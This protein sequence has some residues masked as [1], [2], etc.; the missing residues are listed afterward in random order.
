VDRVAELYTRSW[1]LYSQGELAA[2]RQGFVEVAKSGLFQGAE[3]RRPEDYIA[4]IDR[5]LAAQAAQPAVAPAAQTPAPVPAAVTPVPVPVPV[6][7]SPAPTI[8]TPAPAP[9]PAPNAAAL[10]VAAPVPEQGGSIEA[11]NRKRGI[12][13][14]YTEAAVN[15]AVGQAQK[16]IAQGEFDTAAPAADAAEGMKRSSISERSSTGSI[17][18]A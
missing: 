3:G 10:A 16:L 6:T 4:T 8:V 18:N 5:L 17:P 2:A 14:S 11:I 12:I 9:A 7:P 13:R 1:E 15:D